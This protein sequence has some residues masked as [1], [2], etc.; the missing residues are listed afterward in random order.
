MLLSVEIRLNANKCE[1]I[2]GKL[3]F[4]ALHINLKT[5]YKLFS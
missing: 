1:Q 5:N 2:R 4:C 3:L